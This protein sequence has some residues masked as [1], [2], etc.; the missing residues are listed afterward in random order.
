M[1]KFSVKFR[2]DSIDNQFATQN[3][4]RNSNNN[5][6]TANKEQQQV[7]FLLDFFAENKFVSS[8]SFV[9]MFI[10]HLSIC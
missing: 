1:D 3:D 9:M 5:I 2:T 4:D 10:T 6:Q 7:S 8:V